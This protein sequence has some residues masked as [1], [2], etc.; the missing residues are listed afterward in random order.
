M[1]LVCVV[2]PIRVHDRRHS[3]ALTRTIAWR[4]LPFVGG[5]CYLPKC[6]GRFRRVILLGDARTAR[7]PPRARGHTVEAAEVTCEVT[8]VVAAD[9]GH[10][11]L[12]G[13]KA[14]FE[15]GP[16][17]GHAERPQKFAWGAAGLAAKKVREAGGREVC[18]A[19]EVSDAE[20]LGDS[21]L[22]FL[23]RPGD[24]EIHGTIDFK[25]TAVV[26][27]RSSM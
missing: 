17:L 23:N 21:P 9:D 6:R 15:Q 24:P 22:H 7:R 16:R 19:G 14:A 18:T 27:K 11:F 2:D 13:E 5:C 12:D 1:L 4:I 8:R 25:E 20:R 10:H 3:P 26:R